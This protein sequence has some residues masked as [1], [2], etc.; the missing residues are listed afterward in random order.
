MI[1]TMFSPVGVAGCHGEPVLASYISSERPPYSH[2]EE[3]FTRYYPESEP[4]DTAIL[5]PSL[6]NLFLGPSEWLGCLVVGGDESIDALLQLLDDGE[7]DP[8]E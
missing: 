8:V 2:V 6:V 4:T 1:G 3:A 7:R 5:E